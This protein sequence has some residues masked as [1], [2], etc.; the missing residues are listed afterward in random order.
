MIY[1]VL[2]IFK[3]AIELYIETIVRGF[4]RY[5]KYTRKQIAINALHIKIKNRRYK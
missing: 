3:D 4:E 2:P 1:R 5:A